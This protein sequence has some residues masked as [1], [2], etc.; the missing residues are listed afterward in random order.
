MRRRTVFVLLVIP[1]V[2]GGTILGTVPAG[3]SG[4]GGCGA[5]VTER[6][7]GAVEIRR[8]CFVPTVLHAE[9]GAEVTFANRDRAPHNVL[10][11]NGAWGSFETV[12]REPSTYRF[13]QPGVYAYS[14]SLHPGMVG[15]VV[16]GGVAPTGTDTAAVAA[17]DQ[18][19]VLRTR[20]VRGDPAA[21]DAGPPDPWAAG[22]AMLAVI[23]LTLGLMLRVRR[24]SPLG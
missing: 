12:R 2:L 7:G 8:S 20:M 5:P 11:A 3:A 24:R 10:G 18:R 16:V 21:R 9:P 17:V 4:G 19:P 22:P 6:A 1:G 13:D 15:V 14:C 23:A